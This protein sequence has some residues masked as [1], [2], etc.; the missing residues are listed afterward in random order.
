MARWPSV[1]W[2]T[3]DKYTSVYFCY[4]P[5]ANVQEWR[6]NATIT[7][8]MVPLRMA[9]LA[10]RRRLWEA[11]YLKVIGTATLRPVLSA[12]R[13][14]INV[15]KSHRNNGTS[16]TARSRFSK[17]AI[18]QICTRSS[19]KKTRQR[20]APLWICKWRAGIHIG[21]SWLTSIRDTNSSLILN[22]YQ[23]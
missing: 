8:T 13:G 17:S 2:V 16:F 14:W 4:E 10:E 7:P 1:W 21:L 18:T 15:T 6:D 22:P 19:S 5:M 12:I 3:L 11:R 20:G 23:S 9:L